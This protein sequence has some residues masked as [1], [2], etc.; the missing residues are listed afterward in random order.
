[1]RK[2]AGAIILALSKLRLSSH[3]YHATGLHDFA[4]ILEE[5]KMHSLNISLDTL[6]PE[7]FNLITGE[8]SLIRCIIIS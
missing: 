1:V 8:T 7:K 3:D 6:Q 2:D 4:D 5:A